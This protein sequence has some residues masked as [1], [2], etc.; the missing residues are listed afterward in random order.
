V[1]TEIE[2]R[3]HTWQL[4]RTAGPRLGPAAVDRIA[5]VFWRTRGHTILTV[6]YGSQTTGSSS[7]KGEGALPD[8]WLSAG[9]TLR[10]SMSH[11][12]GTL[13]VALYERTD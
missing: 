3:G 1:P 8:L 11:G 9:Q 5:S 12:T 2:S 13:G 7:P 6:R 4:T 10:A